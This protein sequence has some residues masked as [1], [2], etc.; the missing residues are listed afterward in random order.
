MDLARLY[1]RDVSAF[2][3]DWSLPVLIRRRDAT[4]HVVDAPVG[5]HTAVTDTDAVDLALRETAEGRATI[6]PGA[7]SGTERV[8]M[9]DDVI[10]LEKRRGGAFADRIGI[11]RAPNVDV[12]LVLSKVSKYHGYVTIDDDGVVYLTDAKSTFG[13]FVDGERIAAMEPFAL[14][15]GVSVRFAGYEFRFHTAEGLREVVQRQHR[16]LFRT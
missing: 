13:T 12:Q 3:R 16:V 2:E 6:A 1:G 8:P 9:P 7:A 15:D 10:R 14:G 4:P 11:G 5:F